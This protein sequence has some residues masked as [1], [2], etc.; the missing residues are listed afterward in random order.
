M[1]KYLE[2]TPHNSFRITGY[3]FV[4]SFD[5]YY[6]TENM[7]MWRIKD[8]MKYIG[9][10]TIQLGNDREYYAQVK[11]PVLRGIIR[12]HYSYVRNPERLEVKYRQAQEFQGSKVFPWIRDG[13]FVK[14]DGLKYK[15]FVGVHPPV[16]KNHPCSKIK[17][18]P[19]G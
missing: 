3:N 10:N 9:P 15:K 6:Q 2:N 4:N 11:S 18:S 16:L 19:K 13:K 1:R 7:R 8:G 12:Y 5:W 17:W 14:R